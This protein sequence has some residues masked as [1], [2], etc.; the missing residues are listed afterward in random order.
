MNDPLPFCKFT[1]IQLNPI[2]VPIDFLGISKEVFFSEELNTTTFK[3]T[4]MILQ[5]IYM[6]LVLLLLL[7]TVLSLFSECLFDII[8]GFCF[9][10]VTYVVMVQE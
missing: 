3:F 2:F 6:F 5:F 7:L 1:K 4:Y 8:L 10:D 9:I